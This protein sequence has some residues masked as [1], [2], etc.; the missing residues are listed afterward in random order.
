MTMESKGY[1]DIFLSSARIRGGN[2]LWNNFET[3]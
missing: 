1:G 2:T 3:I